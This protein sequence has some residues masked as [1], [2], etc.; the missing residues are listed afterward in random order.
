MRFKF[1]LFVTTLLILC[2]PSFAEDIPINQS[3][4]VPEYARFEIVQ[5]S[6]LAKL[7]LRLDRVTGETWQ[8]VETKGGSYAW[9]RMPRIKMPND[10]KLPNKVNYQIFL[11]GIRAQLTVLMNTNTGVSWYVAEDPKEGEFWSPME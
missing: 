8:F 10:T 11:S 9:Q 4:T 7:T 2:K 1:I 5:S 6:L 3:S